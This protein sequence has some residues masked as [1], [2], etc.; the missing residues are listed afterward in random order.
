MLLLEERGGV[1]RL[2]VILGAVTGV[3]I[4]FSLAVLLTLIAGVSLAGA[5]NALAY[6]YASGPAIA[7]I[8]ALSGP[9]ACSAIGLTVAYRARL[10]TIASEGQVIAGAIAALWLLA[11]SGL[12]MGPLEGFMAPLLL[13]G[14]LGATIGFLVALLKVKLHVN[15][16]LSSLMINYIILVVAN[17]IIGGPFREGP[18]AITRSVPHE[19]RVSYIIIPAVTGLI[20]L[21]LWF[22][23]SRT[24]LGLA[25]EAYGKAP[26]A[27]ET[28]GY[29]PSRII[30][31]VAL[32]SG[33][34]A[35]IGGAL[36]I[37]GF[38]YS[39]SPMSVFPGYGYM[40][41]LVAWLSANNPLAAFAAS[42]FISSI[43]VYGRLLQ[44]SGVPLGYVLG[45]QALI[46]LSALTAVTLVKYRVRWL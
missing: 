45:A 5:L 11:Y 8:L 41:V 6:T 1:S 27:A 44:A 46:V 36:M 9:I 24:K 23:M 38:Q 13:S 3:L 31:S 37:L 43:A 12:K 19:Y 17:Y 4:G 15:E 26:R 22:L 42:L 34:T 35:G 21:L 33:F 10:I 25:V 29:N 40:G 39:M 18:F 20:T 16:I 7:S 30:F 14:L 28:Y 32:I 2:M